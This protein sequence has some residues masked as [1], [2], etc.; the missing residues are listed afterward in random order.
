MF[1]QKNTIFMPFYGDIFRANFFD[2]KNS[3]TR[4]NNGDLEPLKDFGTNFFPV[5]SPSDIFKPI[6]END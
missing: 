1:F 4:Q 2:L 3:K 6:L 5:K